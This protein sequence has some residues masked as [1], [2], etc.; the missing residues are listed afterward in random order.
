MQ[1]PIPYGRQ[2]ITDA[3]IAAVAEALRSDFLTQGPRI[4]AFEDAFGAYI[5]APHTIA[6]SNGTAALHL[7]AL[8][9]GVGPGTRVITSPITFAASANCI[10]YAG[11]E[12]WFAD[13]DPQTLTLDPAAVRRLLESHP[14]GYFAGLVPVDFAGLPANLPA[15]RAL[16]DEF[17]LWVLEDACHAPGGHITTPDGHIYRCGDGQLA[18]AA[19]FSFHPVKH[20]ACGEGGAVT[21]ARPDVAQRVADLRTHGITRDPARM[22][23]NH[24]GWYHEMQTLGYNYRLTDFQAALGLSQL[25]RADAGLARRQEIAAQYTARLAHL[26]ITLPHVSAGYT[27]AWHLYVIQT[28]RRRELYDHLRAANIFAQVHYIPVYRHPYYQDLGYPPGLCPLAEAYYAR[29]L[30]LP[31]YPTLT[32][33][34]QDYV[35]QVV[36]EFLY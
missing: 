1:P 36:E 33:E 19:I 4:A 12:V 31:M 35:I 14:R 22:R 15:L 23:E 11:G 3:D 9:L 2:N 8:A 5:H 25:S 7:A 6:L 21:T 16:A 20:I 34:Q 10:R 13:I 32:D 30:S 24:G 26:P 27:H 18:E 17:G 28:E 29:C